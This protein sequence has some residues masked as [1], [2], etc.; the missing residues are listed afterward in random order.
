MMNNALRFCKYKLY[1][2]IFKGYSVPTVTAFTK[3]N[4]SLSVYTD[5]YGLYNSTSISVPVGVLLTIVITQLTIGPNSNLN[6]SFNDGTVTV[7]VYNL[8]AGDIF[9]ITKNYTTA[10]VYKINATAVAQNLTGITYSINSLTINVT[11]PTYTCKKL[12]EIQIT[13]YSFDFPPCVCIL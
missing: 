6:V 8:T 4:Y 1:I 13:N 10:G 5:G 9:N 12:L 7:Q 11:Q 2:Y 3:M